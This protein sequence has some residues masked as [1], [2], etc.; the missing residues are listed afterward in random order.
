[1]GPFN[2]GTKFQRK[3]DRPGGQRDC[4]TRES[5]KDDETRKTAKVA[6]Q[7]TELKTAKDDENWRKTCYDE[8]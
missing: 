7:L 2:Y 1:M 6:K 5:A 4:E 8:P 3:T